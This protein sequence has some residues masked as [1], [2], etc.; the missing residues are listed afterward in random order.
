VQSLG[1]QLVIRDH[2]GFFQFGPRLFEMEG[3]EVQDFDARTA[4][5]E[6]PR[7]VAGAAGVPESELAPIAEALEKAGKDVSLG[8]IQ[9]M[10]ERSQAK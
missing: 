5:E 3:A 10:Y 2:G 8:N 7:A 4:I 9:K 1:N 6:D